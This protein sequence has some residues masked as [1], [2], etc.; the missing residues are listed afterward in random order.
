VRASVK[1][2]AYMNRRFKILKRQ[3][4]IDILFGFAD[5]WI[6]GIETM[7]ILAPSYACTEHRAFSLRGRFGVDRLRSRECRWL[8]MMGR[9]NDTDLL[10]ES[11]P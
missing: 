5:T 1:P 2:I 3:I 4:N 10:A 9:Y 8:S 6:A 11:D 7:A